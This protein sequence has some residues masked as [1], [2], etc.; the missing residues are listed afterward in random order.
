MNCI[1]TASSPTSKAVKSIP[2][3]QPGY[4]TRPA[5]LLKPPRLAKAAYTLG[6]SLVRSTN[7]CSTAMK[8]MG[9]SKPNH[10]LSL[11]PSE[12]MVEMVAIK[13]ATNASSRI[14]NA[15][16]SAAG[17]MREAASASRNSVVMTSA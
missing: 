17:A 13:A 15:W 2:V 6:T 11:L 12:I 1:A 10:A 14:I 5:R 9:S 16:F 3:A 4:S 7:A 8:S